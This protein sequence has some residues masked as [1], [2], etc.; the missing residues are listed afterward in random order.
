MNSLVEKY[1]LNDEL[2]KYFPETE[3]KEET[4][5]EVK[6]AEESKAEE[7]KNKN[8]NKFRNRTVANL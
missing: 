3:N 2:K 7:T 1:K 6:P 8:I 4:A 5:E